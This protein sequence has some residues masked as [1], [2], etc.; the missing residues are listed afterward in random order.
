MRLAQALWLLLAEAG[1]PDVR[2]AYQVEDGLMLL[3]TAEDLENVM[4]T[5]VYEV[6]DLLVRVPRFSGPRLDLTRAPQFGASGGGPTPFVADSGGAREPGPASPD[7][8]LSSSPLMERLIDLVVNTVE[9]QSWS[10]RGG[11][12]TIGAYQGCI[13]VHNSLLVHQRLGGYL[14][15]AK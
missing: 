8:G 5:R 1:G 11:R 10:Q 3:S 7:V 12:G 9:P 2:L 4:V 15:A 6:S 14:P 13:V